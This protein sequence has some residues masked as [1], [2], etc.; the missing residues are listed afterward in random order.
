MPIDWTLIR[1]T[2]SSAFDPM[3]QDFARDPYAVYARLR[4]HPGPVHDARL[5]AWLLSRY[6][7]V[8]AAACHPGLVRSMEAFLSAEQI[9][10]RRRA[11][12]WHDMPNHERFVQFSLLESDGDTHR[13]LRMLVMGAFTRARVARHRAM[14]QH[15]V[16][17]LLDH[18]LEVRAFDFVV[19]LAAHVPGH[20]IGNVLG[21]PD[22]DC[23]QLRAWSEQVVQFFDVDRTEAHKRL[24][25]QATGE[26]HLYLRDLIR[27]RRQAPRDDLLT[28]LVQAQDAGRMDET[29]LVSTAMLILMAGHGSTIDA[30]GSGLNALLEHPDQLGL[31]RADPERVPGAVQEMFRYESPLPYFHRYAAGDVTLCGRTFPAGTRFG[32]L[33]GAA[34]RDP[35]AFPDPDAF[36]V[37]RT[38]N[39]HLAFGRGAHLCLGNHLS[40]LD[41]DVIFRTLLARTRSIERCT[42]AVAFR[43]G[44]TTRGP[45]ALPVELTPV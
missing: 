17:G 27:A 26:F 43:P 22:E 24:A 32:L 35:D 2:Q 45:L 18:L 19:D 33:Y 11:A 4:V 9:A 5:D 13:R 7:D 12:N 25:E 37:L 34:N 41:M 8:D 21:V 20:I 14:I 23:P 38:P 40:R 30:L 1:M 31:L 15:Y 28:V 39:R 44:L 6:E 10:Q 36:A 42:D 29:E 3:S 16:D